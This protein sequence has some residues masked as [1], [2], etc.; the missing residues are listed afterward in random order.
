ML[1]TIIYE[2]HF[3]LWLHRDQALVILFYRTFDFQTRIIRSILSLL[4]AVQSRLPLKR[5]SAWEILKYR[6]H[7]S[8]ADS[9]A[10]DILISV[11][12]FDKSS[13]RR[14]LHRYTLARILSVSRFCFRQRQRQSYALTIPQKRGE[15]LGCFAS[16]ASSIRI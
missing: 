5:L 10:L 14:E 13:F 3:R 12:G 15:V 6:C 8:A 7:N 4:S 1:F 2:L 11:N 16:D 9:P